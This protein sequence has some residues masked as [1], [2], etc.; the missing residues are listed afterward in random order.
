MTFYEFF[1][2]KLY[3]CGM[4]KDQCKEVLKLAMEDN[5]LND[6]MDNRWND[7]ISDYPE[8]LLAIIWLSI[9][10]AALKYIEENCPEAWFKPIFQKE[11]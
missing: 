11:K 6:T 8:F 10:D 3:N 7:K 4:F 2:D 9:K 5:V 1:E